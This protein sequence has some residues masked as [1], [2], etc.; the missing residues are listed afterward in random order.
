M[1]CAERNWLPDEEYYAERQQAVISYPKFKKE[2]IQ[3]CRDNFFFLLNAR[4]ALLI[5]GIPLKWTIR[6]NKALNTSAYAR[7]ISP[8]A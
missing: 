5:P 7:N 2:E 8:P 3:L 4:F 1:I 6:L